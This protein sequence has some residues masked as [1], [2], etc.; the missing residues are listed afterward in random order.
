[1]KKTT[2]RHVVR[3]SDA[4]GSFCL[5]LLYNVAA[6]ST[7]FITHY[8]THFNNIIV[9]SHFI[10][11]NSKGSVTEVSCSNKCFDYY[12]KSTGLNGLIAILDS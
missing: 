11:T 2:E 4:C 5:V 3:H 8:A 9:H 6:V 7:R 12:V 10:A 1:M